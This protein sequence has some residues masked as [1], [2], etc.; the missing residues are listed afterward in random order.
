MG[1]LGLRSA[2]AEDAQVLLDGV[3]YGGP[4]TIVL[5]ESVLPTRLALA[6]KS[7]AGL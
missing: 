2:V 5:Q 6:I 1:R 4:E 7:S 3:E